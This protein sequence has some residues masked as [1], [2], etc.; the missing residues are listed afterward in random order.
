MDLQADFIFAADIT[1][2][3]ARLRY[4]TSINAGVT[5]KQFIAAAV[6]AGYNSNT[7]VIQFTKSR[8]LWVAD[9]N[10][11]QLLPDGRLVQVGETA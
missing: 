9:F 11:Y 7:A 1:G 8:R 4:V 2:Q 6:K 5:R 3:A 10:D